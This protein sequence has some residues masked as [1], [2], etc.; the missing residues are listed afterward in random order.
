MDVTDAEKGRTTPRRTNTSKNH[1]L[2]GIQRRPRP[3][4]KLHDLDFRRRG[5]TLASRKQRKQARQTIYVQRPR[6]RIALDDPRVLP[7]DLSGDRRLRNLVGGIVERRYCDSRSKIKHSTSLAK[8]AVKLG[9]DIDVT[10]YHGKIDVVVDSTGLKVFGEGE[11]KVK[12]HG[13]AKHRTWRKLHLMIDPATHQI[14]A[15]LLTDNGV[16][17]SKVVKTLLNETENDV[18]RFYGDGA[19]DPWEVRDE[20]E[21]RGIEQVIPPREDAV[22][23]NRRDGRRKERDAAIRAIGKRGRKG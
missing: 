5:R 19:Y 6:R 4:R 18:G 13:W 17:D 22:L 21:R 10:N 3:T 12:K 23:Q 16:H 15:E 1:Q 11:W 20:L 14:I 8:R 7:N 2:G 9:I